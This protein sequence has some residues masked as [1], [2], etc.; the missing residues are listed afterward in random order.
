MQSKK[1]NNAKLVNFA[2]STVK[3]QAK[4]VLPLLPIKWLL[5]RPDGIY[6]SVNLGW[7]I[8]MYYFEN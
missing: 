3:G 1:S 6:A 5:C 8:E 2:Q 7:L 4:R